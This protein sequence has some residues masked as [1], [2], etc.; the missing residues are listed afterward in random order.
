M[1]PGHD[2][3]DANLDLF[4]LLDRK[5]QK[6]LVRVA[7]KFD[8]VLASEGGV[9][10]EDNSGSAVKSVCFSCTGCGAC[11]DTPPS[12][13]VEEM[14]QQ[15]QHFLIAAQL[16]SSSHVDLRR[17]SDRKVIVETF[18]DL[19]VADNSV[20]QK[21]LGARGNAQNAMGGVPVAKTIT[22]ASGASI[23]F[24]LIDV[25]QDSGACPQRQSDGK[26]GI[27]ED[28]PMKCRVVP[29]DETMPESCAGE[30]I[31]NAIARMWNMGGTCRVDPL[32][33]V[34]WKDGK[35][36][37]E[38][39]RKVHK[40]FAFGET[41]AHGDLTKAIVEEYLDYKAMENNLPRETIEEAIEYMTVK[42]ERPVF[43]LVPA[44]ARMI[45]GGVLSSADAVEVLQDQIKIIEARLPGI[46]PGAP[47]NGIVGTPM[48]E[49]L[50]DWKS[51][52]QTIS[53]AWT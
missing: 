3:F 19:P 46:H 21:A 23:H 43:N 18:S 37:S 30:G 40:I 45:E 31:V 2:T 6:E 1:K 52:Y 15:S 22:N 14:L 12:M 11:C 7:M 5:D 49:I 35:F 47:M 16:R 34:I 48:A 51:L 44:L 17:A 4:D 36:V 33:P 32:A 20:M 29:F 10:V 50:T 9:I 38:S 53:A 39:D 42:R 27:Y 28:R 24:G 13:R 26:C 41:P 25:D 8:V